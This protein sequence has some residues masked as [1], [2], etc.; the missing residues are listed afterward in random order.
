MNTESVVVNTELTGI[1][2]ADIRY[3]RNSAKPNIKRR[4]PVVCI[5]C[6]VARHDNCA[7]KCPCSCRYA[8]GLRMRTESA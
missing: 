7:G 1:L 6:L 8:A 3:N 5:E 4:R 2:A